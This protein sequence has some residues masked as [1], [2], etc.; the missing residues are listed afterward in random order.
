MEDSIASLVAGVDDSSDVPA[1][2][3]SDEACA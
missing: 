1:A 2:A 3:G